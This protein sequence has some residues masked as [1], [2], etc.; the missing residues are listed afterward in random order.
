M[1]ICTNVAFRFYNLAQGKKAILFHI[2]T[3]EY[4]FLEGLSAELLEHILNDS[5]TQLEIWLKSSGLSQN[6]REDFIRILKKFGAFDSEIDSE[7]KIETADKNVFESDEAN[8]YKMNALQNELAEN[9]LIYAFHFDVTNRCNERCIHC[10]HPFERYHVENELTFNE[11]KSV[12]DCAYTLGAFSLTLSGGEALLRPDIFNLIAYASSK[13][14]LIT[15]FTNG[16]LIDEETV[17]KFLKYR[18]N[19]ISVSIYGDSAEVHDRITSVDGSFAKTLL[20][21]Q[22][23]QKNCIPYEVKSVMLGENILRFQEIRA[24]LKEL[25][26]GN[27]GKMDLSITGKIDGDCS[28]YLHKVPNEEIKKIYYSDPIHF[29]GTLDQVHRQS[30]ERPC[31]AGKYTLYCDAEGNIYPCVSFRLFL[32]TYKEL[33]EIRS[34]S[35]LQQWLK[36]KL[37]DFSDC[38]QHDYCD[39]CNEQCAGNNLIENGDYLNSDTSHCERARIIAAWF[40][41]HADYNNITKQRR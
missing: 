40:K 9:G 13:G 20:G 10:Y 7:N 23:L 16:T 2:R 29:I 11:A 21:I 1:N 3:R 28:T 33:M 27:D 24:F 18:I 19:K 34:N 30:S 4:M 36:I 26:H 14:M 39:Y 25:N 22:L 6:D 32:C 41:E 38:F 35:V 15:L 5:D 31:G 37:C 17:K 8:K 12:I